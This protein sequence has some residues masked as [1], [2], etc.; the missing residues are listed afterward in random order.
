M[1]SVSYMPTSENG[2]DRIKVTF[3]VIVDEEFQHVFTFLSAGY[4]EI[5]QTTKR[6]KKVPGGD[7]V[8]ATQPVL[9]DKDGIKIPEPVTA[10]FLKDPVFI[11][12]GAQPIKDWSSLNLPE[13]IP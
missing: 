10:P 2:F 12:G 9:L 4:N 8:E 11:S 3:R 13:S 5:N 6:L 1:D 7:G